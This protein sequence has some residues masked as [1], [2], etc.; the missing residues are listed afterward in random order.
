MVLM[1]MIKLDSFFLT[2]FKNN[3]A[4]LHFRL[5]LPFGKTGLAKLAS[6]A[7]H[8][9]TPEIPFLSIELFLYSK[10]VSQNIGRKVHW[11][12]LDHEKR[13]HFNS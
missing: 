13:Q 2:K 11:V 1:M 6:H 10:C 7:S 5:P 4:S 3:K 12:Q 9:T 8:P